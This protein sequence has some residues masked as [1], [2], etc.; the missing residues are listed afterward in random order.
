MLESLD[1]LP[2]LITLAD[3]DGH[4]PSY[5]EKIYECFRADFIRSKPSF[6]NKRFE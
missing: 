2:D 4:W 3:C 1:W 5:L 6:P